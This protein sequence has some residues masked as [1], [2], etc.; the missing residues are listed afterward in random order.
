MDLNDLEVFAAIL[1][2]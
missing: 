2:I 1:F